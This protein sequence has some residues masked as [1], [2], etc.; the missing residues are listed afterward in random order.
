M[1]INQL[2]GY[3]YGSLSLDESESLRCKHQKYQDKP[4]DSILNEWNWVNNMEIGWFKDSR[5][6]STWQKK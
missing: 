3:G 5:A 4:V 6:Q 1:A 2:H